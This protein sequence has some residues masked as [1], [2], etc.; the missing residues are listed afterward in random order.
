MPSAVGLHRTGSPASQPRLYTGPVEDVAAR[1]TG[2]GGVGVAVV[3]L[4]TDGALLLA[5]QCILPWHDIMTT[6]VG[7][8]SQTFAEIRA[9]KISTSSRCYFGTTNSGKGVTTLWG[10]QGQQEVKEMEVSVA[11]LLISSCI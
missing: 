7:E 4:Q 5:L 10:K 1:Q 8:E 11:I 2:Q 6:K 9:R 3:L